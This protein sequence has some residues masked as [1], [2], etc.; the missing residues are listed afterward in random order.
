MSARLRRALVLTAVLFTAAPAGAEAKLPAPRPPS[1]ASLRALGL[2]IAWP[3]AGTTPVATGSWL[4]LR[5]T[6]TR[7]SAAT[8]AVSLVRVSTRGRRV[9]VVA[10]RRLRRGVFAVTLPRAPDR[11]YQL[12]LDAG[13]RAFWSWYLAR[14]APFSPT[15]GCGVSR[16]RAA[17]MLT[18][19]PAAART[20]ATVTLRI[21]NTGTACLTSGPLVPEWQRRLADGSFQPVA[22]PRGPV[23]A[24]G[25]ISLPGRTSAQPETV[26]AGLPPG[27]YRLVERLQ[28]AVDGSALVLAAPFT[29]LG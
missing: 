12:R 17:A 4:R 5:V 11:L 24:I 19:A 2:R 23:A 1:P 21:A 13:R 10:R 8:V 22:V 26:P 14:N 25:L 7:G 27:E 29:V 28:S 3:T 6:P 9:D 15:D 20:A 18:V 16:D